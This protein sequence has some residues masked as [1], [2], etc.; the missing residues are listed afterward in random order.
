MRLIVLFCLSGFAGTFS[1][2]AFPALLPEIGREQGL[3]DWQLGVIAGAFGFARMC[4]DLP[5]G[6]FITHHLRR[7][8]VAAP[9]L[10]TLG[11]LALG[12][13]GP[14]PLLIAGRAVMGVAHA[15]NMVAA[16]TAILRYQAAG[17]LASALSA[18]EF[19]AMLGILGGTAALGFVPE[20]VPWNLALMITSA[21]Q[22]L[23]IAIAPVVL[24]ALPREAVPASRPLFARRPHGG[25]A[26][27]P[28]TAAVALAFVAG[29]VIAIAYSTLEQFVIPLRASREFDMPRAGIARLLM[30]VQVCDIA[31]LLPAGVLADRHGTSRVLG[32]MLVVFGVAAALVTFGDFVLLAVGC[33]LFG[34]GMASWTLPLSLLRRETPPE[35]VAWRTALYR[36]GVD[37]GIFLG[38]FLSGLLIGR[39]PGVLPGVLA[40]V[41]AVVG[42]TLARRRA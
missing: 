13:G 33:A 36:V 8:L 11:I 6:M 7:A 5:V 32:T 3:A 23:G 24:A 41:L 37:G 34:I 2:G 39:A 14:L 17:R 20:R 4:A 10:I 27:A 22:I 1:I 12:S 31:C 28:A 19:S 21:P 9:L 16:L 25:G 29:G 40:V 35:Q 30:T 38:P 42:V 15:L 26:H 18:F